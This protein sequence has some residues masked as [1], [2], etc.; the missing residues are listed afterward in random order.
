MGF[1]RPNVPECQ[2]TCPYVWL[3]SSSSTLSYQKKEV[4]STPSET[5]LKWS[6]F[7]SLKGTLPSIIQ[8][9]R[10]ACFTYR[11]SNIASLLYTDQRVIYSD[12][13][14][15]LEVTRCIVLSERSRAVPFID[16]LHS[17]LLYV[18]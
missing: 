17:L 12:S 9:K 11:D 7:R 14:L 13:S 5:F 6:T 2:Q 3:V 16:C 18:P 10:Q 15:P 8:Y 1:K 4:V